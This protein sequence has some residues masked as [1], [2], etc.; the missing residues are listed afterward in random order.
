[1]QAALNRIH[2]VMGKDFPLLPL[3][4]LGAFASDAAATLADRDTLLAKAALGNDDTAIAGWLPKLACVREATALLSDALLAAEALGADSGYVDDALDFKLLQFPRSATTHWAALPPAPDQ[5]LRGVV[6]VAAH[7]PGALKGIDAA[8]TL[9]GLYVDEWM[10]TIPSSEETTGLG[11][12]FD[13]PGARPP[14]SILLAV[15]ADLAAENWTLDSLLATVN[16]AMALTRLRAVRPQDLQG[17][18]LL[19]P[20]IFLSN[21]FKQDVPSVD[22]SRLLAKNL[23]VLRAASKQR[24]GSATMAMGTT[25]FTK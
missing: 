21:N 14:Q 19:L 25:Q 3:F 1:M 9:A 6:A 18:G 2:A 15:P 12:H 11:F 23:D 22:F 17:L 24:S 5:D 20:G 10:E 13:A 4:T 8:T 7:A 16:E